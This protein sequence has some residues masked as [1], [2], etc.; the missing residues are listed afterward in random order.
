MRK[1]ENILLFLLTIAFIGLYFSKT[2][3]SFFPYV[4][5]LYGLFQKDGIIRLKSIYKNK[6]IWYLA[7]SKLKQ[8]DFT[9][10]KEILLTLPKSSEDYDNA[11][12]ILNKL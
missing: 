11:Q 5:I 2:V 3:L 10:C 6:A 4:M 1:K 9:A 7:L 12:K 8:K